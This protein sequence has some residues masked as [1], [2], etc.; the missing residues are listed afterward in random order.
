MSKRLKELSEQRGA[1][2][3]A[4]ETLREKVAK[5][6]RSYNAEEGKEVDGLLNKIEGIDGDI[7]RETRAIAATS[8]TPIHLSEGEERDLSKFDLGRALRALAGIGGAQLEG[9]EKEMA[10]E[11][12]K[13]AQDA[14][15]SVR[16][17]TLPRVLV[18]RQD[19]SDIRFARDRRSL[20]A[21][22][23]TSTTG[24]QGG[25]TV[26]TI[27]MGLLDAFYN[28]LVLEKAG[29]TFLEGLRGNVNL[30]RYVKDTDPGFKSENASGTGLSPTTAMLSLTPHRLPAY[31]DISEQLLMQSSAAIESVVRNNLT[32]QLAAR[33]Q[34][35]QINGSGTSNEIAGLLGTSGIGAIYA[36]GANTTS[37]TNANG[38]AQVF[39]DWVNLETAV[40]SVDADIGALGYVTNAKVRGQ[41]KQTRKGLKT[42]TDTSVTDSLMIWTDTNTVNGYNAFVTNGVPSNLAK[43]TSSTLSALIFGNWADFYM[44]FWSGI[45]LEL[46][47]D[48]TLGIQGL[49]R[50]TASVYADS[51]IVRPAS[52]AAC[53][54]IAA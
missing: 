34:V 40:A 37:G 20:T 30:P 25:M 38:A 50:L 5:E 46:L 52:F 47:R 27:P 43:G 15:V 33:L 31:I 14:G 10:S 32:S 2:V 42:P 4:L 44:G 17:L 11:G 24:D 22:G 53:K 6:N 39:P 51:G 26:A 7:Q 29:A 21:T 12:A 48:A 3:K 19:R 23:T 49:Y 54:D 8:S 1:S 9:I 41:A 45:N 28:R 16:G 18:R 35:A 36:G 13:E